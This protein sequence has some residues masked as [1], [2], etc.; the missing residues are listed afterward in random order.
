[1]VAGT[2]SQ[3]LQATVF[4]AAVTVVGALLA[5]G[6]LVNLFKAPDVLVAPAGLIAVFLGVGLTRTGLRLLRETNDT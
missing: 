5:V 1:M 3:I 4:F 6:A 2:R